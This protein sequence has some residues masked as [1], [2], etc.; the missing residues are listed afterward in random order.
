MTVLTSEDVGEFCSPWLMW[1]TTFARDAAI[2]WA[3][4]QVSIRAT[5]VSE[6]RQRQS[7]VS[8]RA[9]SVSE[10]RQRQRH[11]SVRATSASEPR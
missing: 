7:H 10:P 4:G 11:V 8:V 1:H 6:P 3:R 2:W 5:S 9:T